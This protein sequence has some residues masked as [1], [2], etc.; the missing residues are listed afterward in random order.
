MQKLANRIK[1]DISEY[2]T[3]LLRRSTTRS[4]QGRS[5]TLFE[6]IIFLIQS[7]DCAKLDGF[8]ILQHRIL[9][10]LIKSKMKNTR[11]HPMRQLLDRQ[12]DR[13]IRNNTFISS[14]NIFENPNQNNSIFQFP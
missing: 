14:R 12:Y 2:V 13:Y 9:I 7:I 8:D 4:I 6:I 3:V 10:S 11:F 5:E 1:F